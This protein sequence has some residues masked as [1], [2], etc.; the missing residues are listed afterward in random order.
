MK[1]KFNET[2]TDFGKS[3]S[4][5]KI[6]NDAF[7]DRSDKPN[8]LAIQMQRWADPIVSRTQIIKLLKC[9]NS[10]E[11]RDM[12]MSELAE[13]DHI[14]LPFLKPLKVGSNIMI[15]DE[16]AQTSEY[17]DLLEATNE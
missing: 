10:Q 6:T 4:M 3:L 9:V 14:F 1:N 7:S 17:I 2:D 11:E 8:E 13:L 5:T 16:Q 12:L 15:I